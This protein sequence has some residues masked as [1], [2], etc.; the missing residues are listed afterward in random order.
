MVHA[1]VVWALMSMAETVGLAEEGQ[2]TAREEAAMPL[3]NLLHRATMEVL[4]QIPRL[5][6]VVV[7]VEELERQVQ[8]EVV[9]LVATAG[10]EAPIP[11]LGLHCIILVAVVA[12][13]LLERLEAEVQV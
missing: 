1:L 9:L 12:A 11:S 3:P 6:L 10:L 5:L 13:L 7:E 8:E 4:V 2:E